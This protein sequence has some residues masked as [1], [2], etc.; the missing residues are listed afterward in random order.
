MNLL[1]KNKALL[2]LVN[3]ILAFALSLPAFANVTDLSQDRVDVQGEEV[4]NFDVNIENRVQIISDEEYGKLEL[5]KLS[6]RN[7]DIENINE[8]IKQAVLKIRPT[9]LRLV[10]VTMKD[11]Y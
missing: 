8:Q 2:G 11:L 9:S 6:I 7:S 1:K 3:F 5:G 10:A 4:N